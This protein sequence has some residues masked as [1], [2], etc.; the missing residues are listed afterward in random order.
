MTYKLPFGLKAKPLNHYFEHGV[1][2]FS[3]NEGTMHFQVKQITKEAN[4]TIYHGVV[5]D[6]EHLDKLLSTKSIYDVLRSIE[7]VQ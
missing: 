7:V 3:M 6:K 4:G 1:I 5:K 2:K